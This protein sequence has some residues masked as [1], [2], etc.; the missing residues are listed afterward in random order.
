MNPNKPNIDLS[1]LDRYLA[2]GYEAKPDFTA[3]LEKS[4]AKKPLTVA[5]TARLIHTSSR[6]ELEAIFA[7]A[8]KLKDNVYGDRVVFFAPLYVGNFCINDCQYCGFRRNN[9]KAQRLTLNKEQLRSEVA[10]LIDAGHKR[11]I[12]VFGEH[13]KYSADFIADTVREVYSVRTARGSIRR[14]NINAAP[15]DASGYEKVQD[16]GIGTFQIFQESYHQP[17]YHRYHP[18]TTPKGDYI[19]RVNAMDTA[20][21]AGI[22]DMGIGVLAGLYDWR[23]ETLA[24]VAH[25]NYLLE[26]Y[27]VGPHTISFPR[28]QPVQGRP[29]LSEY[30]VSDEDFKKMVAILRMAVPYTGLILTARE[31]AEIRRELLNFGVTQIDAGSRIAIGSYSQKSKDGNKAQFDLADERGLDAVIH[32]VIANDNCPSFC[33]ACYRKGRTG[34]HFME[35]AIPGFIQRFCAPNA[36]LSFAEYLLDSAPEDTRDTGM[37]RIQQEMAKLESD[38][39]RKQVQKKLDAMIESGIRD[40]YF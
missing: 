20:F 14:V 35:Y 16:A 12:L 34:E 24:L 4:L 28:L 38:A 7:T 23:Y 10:A 22:D 27:G 3:I 5:E 18:A 26:T 40:Q 30:L 19:K 11:L 2:S 37:Q 32:D 13:P 36:I 25:A 15:L 39:T 31:N 8:R 6:D 17:T 29:S 1:E 21:R 9:K 33:T